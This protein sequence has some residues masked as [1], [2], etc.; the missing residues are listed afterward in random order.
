VSE[1]DIRAAL[2]D[3]TLDKP[4]G[5]GAGETQLSPGEL[6]VIIARSGLNLR[7]G[8]STQFEI[9]MTLQFGAEV[10]VLSRSGDW[11]QVDIQGDGKADGFVLASFLRRPGE[12]PDPGPDKPKENVPL[13]DQIA[14]LVSKLSNFIAGLRR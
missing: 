14:D 12:I 4:A 9:L 3:F 7:S 2:V 10:H 1:A 5:P 13:D 8:N 11:V 6:H